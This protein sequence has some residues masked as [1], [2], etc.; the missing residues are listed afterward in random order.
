VPSFP[1]LL[2]SCHGLGLFQGEQELEGLV[3]LDRHTKEG[4]GAGGMLL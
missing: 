3:I 1:L 4:P 2:T